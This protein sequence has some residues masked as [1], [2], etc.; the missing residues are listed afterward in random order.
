MQSSDIQTDPEFCAAERD[1]VYK[2]IF[3]RRDVPGSDP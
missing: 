1:A 3:N 2:C